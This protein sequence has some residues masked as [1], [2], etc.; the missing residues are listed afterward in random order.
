MSIA[1]SVKVKLG[2][3]VAAVA[4]LTAPAPASAIAPSH[5]QTYDNGVAVG[6]TCSRVP[7]TGPVDYRERFWFTATIDPA[8]VHGGGQ[9][10]VQ[11]APASLPRVEVMGD[12]VV[13]E[14]S[15]APYPQ[16]RNTAE[17]GCTAQSF[18]VDTLP[19]NDTVILK[20]PG[21]Y[22]F[23]RY[24]FS[25]H[26][27]KA[28]DGPEDPAP[29][30]CFENDSTYYDSPQG[31]YP[32]DDPG[33]GFHWRADTF[34]NIVDV[35]PFNVR[36]DTGSCP[37]N[38]DMS[39]WPAVGYIN[40]YDAGNR[41]GLPTRFGQAGGNS[42]GPSSL[43]MALLRIGAPSPLPDLG[44]VFDGAMQRTRAAVAPNGQNSFD[45][46]R[47][48][49]Y[50]M[51]IGFREA[52]VLVLGRSADAANVT[53][54]ATL[55]Q[56]VATQHPVLVSTA[57]GT[58][59]WGTTGGGHM[60][61]VT[62]IANGNFVV[63]DPAGNF[64]GNPSNHYGAGKCGYGVTYPVAWMKS[65][66]VGRYIVRIGPHTPVRRAASPAARDASAALGSALLVTDTHPESDDNPRTFYLV[67]PKG[68]RAG[69]ID[70]SVVEEIPGAS[71]GKPPASWSEPAQGDPDFDPAPE[72]PPP[73]PRAIAIADPQPGTQL[74][75]TADAGEA[76]ALSVDRWVDGA[77]ASH[78]EL[79]GTGTGQEAAVSSSALVAATPQAPA[80]APGPAAVTPAVTPRVTRLA[81]SPASFH[82]RRSAR[83]SF[84]LNIAASVRFTVQRR[85]GSRYVKVRG[86]FTRAGKPGVN[87]FTFRTRLF[88]GKLGAGRYRL[89]AV[90]SAGGRTGAAARA[91]FR[92]RG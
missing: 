2:T 38:G 46:Y 56:E 68:R 92:V 15:A 63:M 50:L 59:R 71:A 47:A 43:L 87:R 72:D 20:R 60:I 73:M 24:D 21:P 25:T 16:G 80:T 40:Q 91:R 90:P 85:R 48:T 30:P 36:G 22:V 23:M 49:A 28:A 88:R 34:C 42:C 76:Y 44:T 83:V 3:A 89:V 54:L 70:G 55:Y 33:D 51:S 4:A 8:R 66:I 31:N 53:N 12:A 7:A 65:A 75:V 57:F 37:A 41:L 64:F 6:T 32:T 18:S 10:G 13:D 52:R 5:N 1:G 9:G 29:S 39:S 74:R 11:I 69:W 27:V 45:P 62:G 81:V 67:D 84:H 58:R 82:A 61:A 19:N 78:D 17:D 79:T 77:V 26:W 86:T 14:L 35:I